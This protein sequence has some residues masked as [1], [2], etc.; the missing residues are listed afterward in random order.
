MKTTDNSGNMKVVGTIR[1]R[2]GRHSSRGFTLVEILVALLV[3][4][5]GLVGLAM[6]QATGLKYNSD[7]YLRSQA[8]MLAYDIIDRMRAN[9]T[10]ADAGYY[11][12]TNTS[13]TCSTTAAPG[14]AETCGDSTSGCSG[15]Q[16]L[17]NYDLSRW[18]AL[19]TTA[20]TTGAAPSSISRTATTSS[21]NTIYQYTITMR[22][23][24]R[25]SNV[26]QAW[27]VEL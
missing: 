18:Y 7:S 23:S 26:E 6:L 1:R 21:G 19:Q 8:T 13:G 2:P 22:W 12:L 15:A 14:A 3:L 25:G 27:T 5:F 16:Q 20:L 9:K 4:S 10:G 17:A 24:E 11:C